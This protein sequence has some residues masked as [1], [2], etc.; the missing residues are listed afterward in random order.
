ML[1]YL[2]LFFV[3]NSF[4]ISIRAQNTPS[5]FTLEGKINAKNGIIKLMAVGLDNY[6]PDNKSYHEAKVINGRF[7]IKDSIYYPYAF[8]IIFKNDSG[9]ITYLSDLFL[10]DSGIQTIICNTDSIRKIPDIDNNSMQELRESYTNAIQSVQN[11]D[12]AGTKKDRVLLQYTKTHPNSFVALWELVFRF[13]YGYK[14]VFDS[15]YSQ[16]STSLKNTNT[17]KTLGKRLEAA[18]SIGIG[19]IFP[20]L[21]LRS[22]KDLKELKPVECFKKYTLIDFWFAHCGACISEFPKLK[23]GFTSYNDKGFNIIGISRDNEE[24]ISDWKTAIKKYNLPWAQ[25]L[26]M[27]GKETMKLNIEAFPTNF[28]LDS[29]RKI[30]KTNIQPDD[31]QVFLEKNLK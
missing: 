15:I 9:N 20:Q 13:S 4:Q 12:P 18:S 25:Y 3:F 5:S 7:I 1:K 29:T 31:L 8:R 11:E 22:L 24:M 21:L 27:N 28:L 2:L 14:P 19:K 6:Y 16:F 30:I 17:G 23:M 26:D 10:I